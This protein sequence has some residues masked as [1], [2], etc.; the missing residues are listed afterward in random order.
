MSTKGYTVL[1]WVTW[2]IATRVAKR[3]MSQNKVKIGAAATVLL[4]L[5]GG[6]VAARASGGDDQE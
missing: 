1:G 2:Q 4:V 5:V 3:K 6:L